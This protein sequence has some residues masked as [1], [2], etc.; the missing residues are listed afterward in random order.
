MTII[1]TSSLRKLKSKGIDTTTIEALYP[2]LEISA[3]K[4]FDAK[5]LTKFRN[6]NGPMPC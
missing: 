5:G 6:L 3:L 4:H 1:L 2:A